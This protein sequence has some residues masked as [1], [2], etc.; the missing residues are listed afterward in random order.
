[1][2]VLALTSALLALGIGSCAGERVAQQPKRVPAETRVVAMTLDEK[3][4]A[5]SGCGLRLAAP[6]TKEDLLESWGRKA[7]EEPGFDMALVGLGMT[8]EREPWRSH[9]VNLWHFDTEAI[10]DEGA[11]KRLAERMMEMTQGS[12][13]LE[14]IKDHVDIDNSQ[15]WLSFTFRGKPIKIDCK[16]E[17]DWVDPA[18][19]GKFV[20]LLNQSD[21]NK[22][23]IYHDLGEAQDCII[24]C[25]TRSE[26]E[27]LR[28]LDAKFIPL[29]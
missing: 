28:S 19:F 1:M 9:C 20:E 8:E 7:F 22:L 3:L 15:A 25:V 18:I 17:D 21:P 16:V 27:C 26:F 14:N 11:Y 6:F 29:K 10:E 4:V 23:Y 2:K 12:L 24:G 13:K 5:L